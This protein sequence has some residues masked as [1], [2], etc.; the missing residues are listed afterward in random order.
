MNTR[1]HQDTQMPSKN[2]QMK[3]KLEKKLK[4]PKRFMQKKQ[5]SSFAA[6]NISGST[7]IN[8]QYKPTVFTKSQQ[9]GKMT[10][11]NTINSSMGAEME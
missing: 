2:Q 7:R 6:S 4:A 5:E 11:D 10:L 8:S 9:F 1:Y 3:R